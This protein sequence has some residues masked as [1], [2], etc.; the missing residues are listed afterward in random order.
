[1]ID[2]ISLAHFNIANYVL[3][4]EKTSQD[5]LLGSVVDMANGEIHYT[6][7]RCSYMIDNSTY[8]KNDYR[9]K[10]QDDATLKLL[11]IDYNNDK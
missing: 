3:D 10:I 9:Y 7:E 1:M 6:L 5:F 2:R 4:D 8:F 11:S